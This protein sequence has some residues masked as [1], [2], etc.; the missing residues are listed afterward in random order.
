MTHAQDLTFDIIGKAGFHY[1]FESIGKTSPKRHVFETAF[2]S[3]SNLLA[4]LFGNWVRKIPTEKNLRHNKAVMEMNRIIAGIINERIRALAEGKDST[5]DLLDQIIRSNSVEKVMTNDEIRHNV[6][7]L[8]LAGHETSYFRSFSITFELIE[9]RSGTLVSSMYLL[10][11]NPSVLN[12][13][14]E[15]VNRVCGKNT[16]TVDDLPKMPLLNATLKV[17][18]LA[19]LLLF[20]LIKL[21]DSA[22]PS[23]DRKHHL[24]YSFGGYHAL[25]L[26][27]SQR[28]STQHATLSSSPV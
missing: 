26:F 27:H 6:G 4:I 5:D 13:L 15:E 18:A 23:S 19:S 21:G 28:H 16:P 24:S 9:A 10:A 8:F 2:D 25:R 7:L 14:F 22:Y 3:V 12:E 20:P 11:K 17:S 1:E